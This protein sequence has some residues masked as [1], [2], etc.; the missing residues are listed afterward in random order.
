M[1]CYCT[2]IKMSDKCGEMI[3]LSPAVRNVK[4]CA[5]ILEKNLAVRNSVCNYQRTQQVHLQVF[6]LEKC[7]PTEVLTFEVLTTRV[8]AICIRPLPLSNAIRQIRV[9][10]QVLSL[11]GH[12]K[13]RV[14]PDQIW[15]G[16][17][18]STKRALFHLVMASTVFL[19]L[20]FKNGL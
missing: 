5:I 9:Y 3:H 10:R 12:Q 15:K 18:G 1:R 4:C 17:V 7:K 13:V 16:V 19:F 2:S 11:C 8:A 6:I 20:R 14:A